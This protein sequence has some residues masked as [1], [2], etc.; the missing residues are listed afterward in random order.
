MAF[1]CTETSAQ[2]ATLTPVDK[3]VG[4]SMGSCW[5]GATS[6]DQSFHGLQSIN[7]TDRFVADAWP[8]WR[9]TADVAV[10]SAWLHEELVSS[11]SANVQ[12]GGNGPICSWAAIAS[13][14]DSTAFEVNRDCIIRVSYAE[15]S[16]EMPQLPQLSWSGRSVIVPLGITDMVATSSVRY[17]VFQST[18][19][20]TRHQGMSLYNGFLRSNL[21]VSVLS[22]CTD[23]VLESNSRSCER[24]ESTVLRFI[25]DG[26]DRLLHRWYRNGLAVRDGF[27]P[28]GSFISG[29]TTETLTI[30]NTAIEDAGQY[31]CVV[32]G[33]YG[34]AFASCT[35]AVSQV[36]TL[37]VSSRVCPITLNPKGTFLRADDDA[38]AQQPTIFA[39]ASCGVVPGD[40]IRVGLNSPVYP[41]G[42][43]TQVPRE[44]AIAVFSSSDV[45]LARDQR[46]RV[47]GAI[48]PV[49]PVTAADTPDIAQG[50]TDI[51]QDFLVRDGDLIEVPAGATHFI[52]MAEPVD[53]CRASENL[54]VNPGP[55]GTR[56]R[57]FSCERP[58]IVRQPQPSSGC[59]NGVG[60]MTVTAAN[61]GP[62]NYQWRRRNSNGTYTN[63]VDGPTGAGSSISGARSATL[64]IS[65][66]T[67]A[68]AGLY[69]VVVSNCG[70]TVTSLDIPYVTTVGPAIIDTHPQSTLACA[71]GLS[72]FTLTPRG[73]NGPF[74]FRWEW[75]APTPEATWQ[76]VADGYTDAFGNVSGATTGTLS[77]V[78]L[79]RALSGALFR[80]VLSNACSSVTTNVAEARVC[81][82]DF[83]CDDVTDFFDYL[84]FIALFGLEDILADYNADGVVDFFDYLDFSFELEQG[85]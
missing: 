10:F 1:V 72:Q 70:G 18:N 14:T 59:L 28:Y 9:A 71:Q 13:F 60:T 20:R 7:A 82:A 62:W 85:C 2:Q 67:Q 22:L 38:A 37:D 23:I 44:N 64:R 54:P 17:R 50:P 81:A 61:W 78:G 6:V 53:G 43:N 8:S 4:Y 51:P 34:P 76:T 19:I 30:T 55:G 12:F 39:L 79:P 15:S 73:S 57:L 56:V 84:D 11:F 21:E 3:T 27:T 25:V 45:L 31:Y 69:S 33:P 83:N 48:S 46:F 77:I 36:A 16:S 24:A 52:I 47:Q 66:S 58:V 74:A 5:S 40:K 65:G 41:C 35:D 80:C 29:A 26:S 42:D 32:T 63:L 49:P 68:D 75:L